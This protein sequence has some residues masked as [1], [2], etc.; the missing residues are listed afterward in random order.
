MSDGQSPWSMAIFLLFI[1]ID[2]IFYGFGSAIQS[3]NESSL[4][5]AAEDGDKKA[6]RL[7]HIIDHPA[8]FINM[9]QIAANVVGIVTGGYI[10]GRIRSDVLRLLYQKLQYQADIWLKIVTVVGVA[11]VLLLLLLSFGITIPKKC[12]ARNPEK[13]AYKLLPFVMAATGILYPFTVL[14]T[15]LSNLVLKLIGIDPYAQEDNVTEEEIMSMVNEGHEQGVL[16]ASEAEMITNIFEFGDKEAADI[17]THRKNVVAVEA[18]MPLGEAVEFIL[19]ES[20]SRFPVYEKDLDDI[21]GILHLKDAMIYAE[22][23]EYLDKPVGSIEGLLRDAHFIPETRNINLLFKEMQSQK[24]HMEIVVDE[25]GQTA[26]IVTMED[27][28]EEIVGNILDEYDEDEQFIQTVDDKTWLM[29]GMTPLED[30]SEVLDIDFE[31]AEYDT[32]NGFLISLLDRIPQEGEEL[33]GEYEGYRFTILSVENKMI[34]TV[35]VEALE[36]EGESR[37]DEEAEK[38]H[39]RWDRKSRDSR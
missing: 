29:A 11:L 37:A 18:E 8:K 4:E 39:D 2:A 21:T 33:V 20:N 36:N 24:I 12:A 15:G 14:V 34:Q 9:N 1:V 38:S 32:L 6:E 19:H 5:K 22:T 35:R 10:L 30:V 25:Y 16:L 31:E 27:I 3:L 23:E 26:G 7:L 28:L 13:W 17:M